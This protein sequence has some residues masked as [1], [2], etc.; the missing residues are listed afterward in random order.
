MESPIYDLA[1]GRKMPALGFGTWELRGKE[2]EA[3]VRHALDVGYRHIDTAD[4]YRNHEA[5]GRALADRDREELFLTT[6]VWHDRLGYDDVIADAERFLRE[7]H[8]EYVDLLLI[9]WPNRAIPMAGTFKALKE[10]A[11]SGKTRSIGV[12]NFTIGHLEHA[13]AVSDAPIVTNQVEFHPRLYQKELLDY[14]AER[15]IVITAY[16]PILHGEA[17]DEPVLRDI[18]GKH[19]A[20]PVQVCLRW[21]LQHGAAAIPRSGSPEHIEDNWRCLGL[22]L[23]EDD[24][25]RIDGLNRD[26]RYLDPEGIS[27]FD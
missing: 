26:E 2:G 1:D 3:A 25:R 12:S 14:C 9:H 7:L 27:E 23:D 5:V 13:L 6:K 19:D 11:E 21:L 24:M 16:R 10:V 17:A 18:A 8:V 20:T 4:M 22:D 15:D